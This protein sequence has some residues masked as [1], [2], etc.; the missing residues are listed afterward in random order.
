MYSFGKNEQKT[1]G[2]AISPRD[3]DFSVR[4]L[5]GNRIED[6]AVPTLTA[7]RVNQPFAVFEDTKTKKRLG[8]SKRQLARGTLLVGAPGEGK[9]NLMH[10]LLTGLLRAQGEADKIIIFDTKGDYL[11]EHGWKIPKDQL[12]VIGTSSE[13]EDITKVWNMFSEIL[14]KDAQGNYKYSK[15]CD[16]YAKELAKTLFSDM[17]SESQPIFPKMSEGL[18]KTIMIYLMR[19]YWKTN[20][21]KLN[22]EEFASFFRSKTNEE[23]KAILNEDIIKDYRGALDYISNKSNQ[24]QGVKSYIEA[25][26]DDVFVDCFAMHDK[27]RE[28]SMREIIRSNKKAVVF[29]EYDLE[30]GDTLGPIY[31]LLFDYAFKY[32]LG[33]RDKNKGNTYFFI[34]EM[35]QIQKLTHLG[36][37]MCFGR[38]ITVD[39][40]TKESQGVRVIAGLQSIG[41]LE[42]IYEEKG[43]QT[44]LASFQTIISFRLSDFESREFVSKRFG[45]N[46]QGLS[47]NVKNNHVNSERAGQSLEEWD[48]MNLE[49]GQAAIMMPN[50]KPF[51]FQFPKYESK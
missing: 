50:E 10:M 15:K 33:G 18:S 14:P 40:R 16:K 8:F 1:I 45:A 49:R 9:S 28:F 20:P 43:A 21:E 32:A 42:E 48:I 22:N 37:A 2:T 23:L 25:M 44:K 24:T 3:E 19:K 46:Y 51:L 26:V 11:R 39:E 41:Q 36:D 38:E 7:N 17:Q 12:Y 30:L 31:K 5:H 29:I 6:N 47:Y 13:Y 35:A 4:V 27:A 34:D